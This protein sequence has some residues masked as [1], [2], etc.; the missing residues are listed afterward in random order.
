MGYALKIWLA[1]AACGWLGAAELRNAAFRVELGVDGEGRPALSS[2]AWS[3]PKR[4]AA[5]AWRISEDAVFHRAELDQELPGSLRMTW[6]VELA[7]EGALVRL[8]GRMANRGAAPARVDSFPVWAEAWNVPGA[9]TL[10]WWD[11]VTFRASESGLGTGRLG[12]RL[13]SSEEKGANPYWMVGDLRFALEWC[14]GWEARI[15]GGAFA[16][17]LPPEETQLVLAPGESMEGPAL[18]VS[19]GASRA[20]WMSRRW[21]VR[22]ALYGGPPPAYPLVYNHW[23]AMR[24]NLTAAALRAQ[25]EAAP[26]YGFDAFVIDAGWYGKTGEWTPAASKFQPGEFEGLLRNVKERGMKAG[27][28]SCPQFVDE[29][30]DALPPEVDRPGH[31]LKLINGH[32]L[33]LAA[34][35]RQRLPSH[36]AMLR[37]RYSADWWKYDQALFVQETRGGAMRNVRAFQ[38]ALGAVRRG[39]PDLVIENCQS[40]GRMINEFTAL[41]TDMH[42]LRDGGING[43]KHARQNIETVLGALEF[44][45]PWTAFRW[46]NRPDEIADPELLRLYCRSAMAGV[47]GISADQAKIA[48]AQR[49]VILKEVRH[50]GGPLCCGRRQVSHLRGGSQPG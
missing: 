35:F 48:P 6:V 45:P 37:E 3:G 32:L 47:W 46:T 34:V 27:I 14:G 28:W 20:A 33:D 11:A 30:A 36:V 26:T 31:F 41:A 15:E 24:F 43:L 42:W 38:D 16:V 29:P 22:R 5:G 1:A 23:Y 9:K 17:R 50:Y 12:S 18:W 19:A 13:H 40:G 21:T 8:H 10:R 25:V 7:R 39:N 4:A 2:P 49:A 44:L